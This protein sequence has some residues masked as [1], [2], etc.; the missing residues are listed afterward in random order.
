MVRI[1]EYQKNPTVSDLKKTKTEIYLIKEKSLVLTI[2]ILDL[3]VKR[4]F[5]IPVV[6]NFSQNL[7]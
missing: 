5:K 1:T 3:F 6:K 4:G 7:R 2:T